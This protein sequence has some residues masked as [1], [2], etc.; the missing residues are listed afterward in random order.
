[1]SVSSCHRDIGIPINF[2]EESGIVISEALHAALRSRCQREESLPVEIT[3]GPRA[4]S[5]VCTGVSDIPSSCEMKDEPA[6][7]PMQGN[8]PSFKSGHL[9]VH[10]T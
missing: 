4:F 1:M 5:M 3:R 10:S 2:Q 7:K 6:F 9:N 8:Q